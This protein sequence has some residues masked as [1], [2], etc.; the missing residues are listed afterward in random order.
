MADARASRHQQP[1]P[2]RGSPAASCRVF[3]YGTLLEPGR[4]KKLF[5]RR[6][7]PVAATLAGWSKSRCVGRYYGIIR[8]PG[9]VT[10]GGILHLTRFEMTLADRWE[11]VPKL[12]VRRRLRMRANDSA[13]TVRCWT[14]VPNAA[15]PEAGSGA[16]RRLNPS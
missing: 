3:A 4:Q 5:G 9:A 6:V 14:Y 8:R 12:Y 16:A 11:Q 1:R 10:H 15:E 7:H 13:A 2:K